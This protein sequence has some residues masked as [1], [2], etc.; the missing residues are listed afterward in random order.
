[1]TLQLPFTDCES[2]YRL[3]KTLRLEKSPNAVEG[4]KIT[5]HCKNQDFSRDTVAIPS[6]VL[7]STDYGSW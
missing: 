6:R 2:K 5:N 7:H 3:F 1:M 4:D